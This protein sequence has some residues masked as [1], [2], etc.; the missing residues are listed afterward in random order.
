M[1]TLVN[2]LF[3]SAVI[4]A[5]AGILSFSLG[6]SFWAC[7]LPAALLVCFVVR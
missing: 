3:E 6:F 7:I 5:A 1:K 4:L 2:V